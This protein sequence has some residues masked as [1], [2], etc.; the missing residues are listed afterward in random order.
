MPHRARPFFAAVLLCCAV[1]VPPHAFAQQKP[2]VQAHASGGTPQLQAVRRTETIVLDGRLDEPFWRTVPAATEFRQRDPHE[3]RPA[4]ER[5]EVRVAYDDDALYI[6]AR[7]YDSLGAAG[8]RTMLGRRD[9]QLEGDWLE[10]DF[11]TYHDHT[12]LTIIQVNPSGIKWDAGQASSYADP[13]WD[14]VYQAQVHRDSAGWTAEFR[15]P[16]S[17]LRFPRDSVQSWGMQV[18]R[19]IERKNETDVWSFWGKNESGGPSRFGHLTGLRAPPPRRSIELLPYALARGS[20]VRPS[21]PGSP[22]EDGREGSLRVGGDVKALLTSTLTLDATINPD[23]GQVEVDP[24]VVNLSQFETFYS[25]K[26]PFFVEGSGLFDFGSFNCHF[27]SNINS[28]APFYSRRIGRSPQGFVTQA[29]TFVHTPESSNIL[30]A[31]KVTGRLAGGLQIGVMDAVTRRERALAIS[32]EGD[33]FTEEVEPATNYFVGRVRQ[34]L[35]EGNLTV[36]GIATSVLRGFDSDALRGY[37]PTRAEAVGGD[38]SLYWKN[39]GYSLIGNLVVSEVG[40]DSAA[41]DR[42]QHAPARYF[43]RPDRSAGGNGLFSDRLDGGARS[44]R[45]FGGYTRLGKG[46]GNWRFETA[47]DF[48]SPGFETNDL[49]YLPLADYVWNNFNLMRVWNKPT[50]HYRD[51]IAIVG[52]QQ[53]V[54]FDGDLTSRD[55][56]AYVGGQLANYW[57]VSA[58][59]IWTSAASDDR[60]TRGGPVVRTPSDMLYVVNVSTDPRKRVVLSTS[61]RYDRTGEGAASWSADLGVRVKPASNVQVSAGPAYNLSRTRHQYVTRF[62]DP[63]ATHF[64]GERVVFSDLE[65]HTVSMDTRLNWTFSPTLTL[66]LFAQPFVSTGR[67]DNFKEF[68]RPRSIQ[69]QVYDGQQLTQ[70]TANGRVVSYTVDPDRNAATENATFDNPDFNFRSLRGNAV[71]RWEYRPGSTLFLVWTQQRSGVEPFGSFD[72]SRDAPGV[73]DPHPDN[74]FVVKVSYWFGR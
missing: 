9:Q 30:G 25:E 23:F 69:K 60:L 53:S 71:L 57:N 11:D 37:L 18:V 8:V 39:R 35:R 68:V 52:T 5:T 7:M 61:P 41:I 42:L 56:H 66:E 34:N 44:L 20:F 13:S 74:V 32:P 45:G 10:L 14:P 47:V 67:F 21:Q 65:Q 50:R 38:W 51:M 26:R 1:L 17:Q 24:A 36:G 43:Q 48:R 22:F 49:G 73:F 62:D 70:T 72:F 2:V 28:M 3:G 46:T 19:F 33:R 27:C 58:F 40:G 59:T 16:F 64:Y 15:V 6:G 54:N 4:S 55:V 31:A 29:A 63:S 12:G